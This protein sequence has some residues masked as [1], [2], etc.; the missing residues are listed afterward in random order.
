MLDTLQDSVPLFE[1][2]AP[3]FAENPY[4]FY[5]RLREEAPVYFHPGHKFWAISR[6]ADVA[7]AHADTRTFSST[8][9]VTIEGVEASQPI[10]IVQDGKKHAVAKSMMISLFTASR[11]AELDGFIRRTAIK[12]IEEAAEKAGTGEANFVS[13]VTVKLPL[14]V[15]GELIGIP[16]ELRDEVHRLSNTVV[17]RGPDSSIAATTEAQGALLKLYLGLAGERR[18]SL[19]DDPISKL[20]RAEVK[21]EDG[22][23][24]RM[25]DLT[26]AFRFLELGFAGHETVAKAIPNGAM[27]LANFSDERRKLAADMSLLPRAV[28]EML[29]FDPP[30][31]LQGRLTLRDTEVAGVQIPEGQR[32][33]LMTG[34][35]LRDPRAFADPDRFII[36]REP[37][38]NSIAFGHGVHKC[39]GIHLA[40]RE[41]NIFFEELFA[42]FPDWE[43]FPERTQRSVLS[44]VRGVSVLPISFGRHA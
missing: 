12:Y 26:I 27:A 28:D 24:H 33:M 30:S 4:P 43:V 32:V 6:Y 21:D 14:E 8:G 39:L 11:M 44:N 9:G 38:R 31:H 37:D 15:I 40:R 10:L 17:M 41:I 35:A 36:D 22:E 42:R 1:P 18:N 16:V 2:Y 13:D 23:V 3:E 19:G 34:A 20:V 7:K 29:R 5:E 25:D